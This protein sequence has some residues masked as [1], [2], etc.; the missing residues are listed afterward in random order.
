[1]LFKRMNSD[2]QWSSKIDLSWGGWGP[3][4]WTTC[5]RSF[6]PSSTHFGDKI[7]HFQKGKL[8][9][10][11][12][13]QS[14]RERCGSNLGSIYSGQWRS[15]YSGGRRGTQGAVF[16]RFQSNFRSIWEHVCGCSLNVIL[17][18]RVR[19]Q[20]DC[21]DC[22]W[23]IACTTTELYTRIQIHFRFIFIRWG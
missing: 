19:R 12:F 18:Q 5:S 10:P 1:M 7:L 8:P 3:A 6:Q 20:W 15:K 21:R 9:F 22:Y 17:L 13:H 2:R 14:E 4:S 11:P 16:P 23:H